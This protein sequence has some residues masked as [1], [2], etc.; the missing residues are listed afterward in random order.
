M[1]SLVFDL[2]ED[3]PIF[4]L[5]FGDDSSTHRRVAIV[6]SIHDAI[7]L[8]ALVSVSFRFAVSSAT[9]S[10]TKTNSNG[11][12]RGR[13]FFSSSGRAPY[14]KAFAFSWATLS[15]GHYLVDSSSHTF[16]K[17]FKKLRSAI[18]SSTSSINPFASEDKDA[19]REVDDDDNREEIQKSEKKSAVKKQ[20]QEQREA[21]EYVNTKLNRI[22]STFSRSKTS[23]V[24]RALLLSPFDAVA[25]GIFS[26]HFTGR[27]KCIE[28]VVDL[29]FRQRR[30]DVLFPTVMIAMM[31]RLTPELTKSK[32]RTNVAAAA[33]AGSDHEEKEKIIH[34]NNNS[35]REFF[36]M[37]F[38][39]PLFAAGAMRT[40]SH[41]W[42]MTSPTASYSSS[43]SSS[44]TSADTGTVSSR[45]RA[46]NLML[47]GAK[48]ITVATI[49]ASS[50]FIR[51]LA[52]LRHLPSAT[53]QAVAVSM[54]F[55]SIL[56][57]SATYLAFCHFAAMVVAVTALSIQSNMLSADIEKDSE[58]ENTS[59][60]RS[61]HGKYLTYAA[62]VNLPSHLSE[63][64]FSSAT[65]QVGLTLVA[66]A[67]YDCAVASF[68]GFSC[69]ERGRNRI[70]AQ[71][72]QVLENEKVEIEKALT[73]FELIDDAAL[74]AKNNKNDNKVNDDAV[75]RVVGLK[76]RKA[77]LEATSK[78]VEEIERILKKEEQSFFS[79][80]SE[81]EIKS[82]S[83]SSSNV[84]RWLQTEYQIR[85]VVPSILD[86]NAMSTKEQTELLTAAVLKL[87]KK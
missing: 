16:E 83:S 2:S 49:S 70:V 85:K 29:I 52:A 5:F 41:R 18:Q 73:P 53:R 54:Q 11:L 34:N 42:S 58:N 39:L 67:I 37:F 84:P 31:V 10:S 24:I 51:A 82:P 1:N 15:A 9:A 6:S 46:V 25:V 13:F 76:K 78:R 22:P 4:R 3:N 32:N 45:R 81:D 57:M 64:A 50:M 30:F 33:G 35:H 66:N 19:I 87:L 75:E 65:N 38:L 79:D 8:S 55:P 26:S 44:S 27:P 63:V 43:S 74:T 72:V 59:K 56:F 86:D 77:I 7:F 69:S 68:D 23:E 40:V 62:S 17:R 60:H 80:H 61:R 20:Q 47:S 71:L 14:V 21:D 48:N 28:G 12:L 36:T